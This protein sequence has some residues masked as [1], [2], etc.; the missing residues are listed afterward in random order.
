MLGDDEIVLTLSAT[1]EAPFGL[2]HTGNAVFNRLWTLLHTPAV[3]APWRRGPKG[4]PLGLQLVAA[5]GFEDRLLRAAH[6]A[7]QRLAAAPQH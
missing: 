1:G 7:D 2:A 4:L 5:R 6:W 3:H